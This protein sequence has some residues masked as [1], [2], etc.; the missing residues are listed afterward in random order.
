VLVSLSGGF[1]R[2]ERAM[3][4]SGEASRR[5]IAAVHAE[6]VA[7]NA[8]FDRLEGNIQAYLEA[9]FDR[10]HARALSRCLEHR[11]RFAPPHDAMDL[12]TFSNC[13]VDFRTRGAADA[14]DALLVD[15]TTPATDDAALVAALADTS[16]HNFARR[17]PLIARAAA[18]RHGHGAA[19]GTLVNAVEWAVAAEAYVRMLDDWPALATAVTTADLD[20][21]IAAGQELDTWSRRLTTDATGRPSADL[22]DAALRDYA[23]G[24]AELRAVVESFA[25]GQQERRLQRIPRDSLVREIV[26]ADG[27]GRALD[28]PR[29]LVDRLPADALAAGMLGLH[30]LELRY[31]VVLDDSIVRDNFRRPFLRGTRHDRHHYVR[32]ALVVEALAGGTVVRTFEA[33][34]TPIRH[35][36][37]QM[38][39]GADSERVR[40]TRVLEPDPAARFLASDWPRIH[41]DGDWQVRP[42]AA[43]ALAPLRTAVEAELEHYAAQTLDDLFG[44]VCTGR[45]PPTGAAAEAGRIRQALATMTT[46][47][48]LFNAYARAGLSR[49]AAF[50]PVLADLVAGDGSLVDQAALCGRLQ[51]GDRMLRVLWL[52]DAPARA[53]ARASAFIAT[54]FADA[55]SLPEP[56]DLVAATL[57]RLHAARRIQATRTAGGS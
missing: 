50:D 46:A 22:F 37:D 36:T 2:L 53:A 28:V 9:G 20:A 54:R 7:L 48:T 14:R 43:G 18:A 24:A 39:G 10:D 32:P 8:R 34:G 33:T 21:L 1:E 35:R 49:T 3:A 57:E 40:S 5:E 38:A 31:H 15:R 29:G 27:Q 44:A 13:L 41:H 4:L 25:Q 55:A 23:R 11:Q 12:A 52:D 45:Q 56:L 47:R 16:R 17:V 51:R 19:T 26:A 6:V 42:A 30:P